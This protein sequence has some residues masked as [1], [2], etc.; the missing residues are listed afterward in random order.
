MQKSILFFKFDPTIWV[1]FQA[2]RAK[3]HNLISEYIH[4]FKFN[5]YFLHYH[6]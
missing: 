4:K 5:K 1:L 3:I 6:V 2:Y